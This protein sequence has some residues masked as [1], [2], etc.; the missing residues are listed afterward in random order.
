M[1]LMGGGG[2]GVHRKVRHEVHEGCLGRLGMRLMRD[3]EVGVGAC[4]YGW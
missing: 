1:R 4:T 3:G 2:E